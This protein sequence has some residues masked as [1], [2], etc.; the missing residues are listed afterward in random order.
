METENA[1]I[2]IKIVYDI[3]KKDI[4][5]YQILL[6]FFFSLFF[7]RFT[8]RIKC[9]RRMSFKSS[10]FMRGSGAQVV[11]ETYLKFILGLCLMISTRYHN[12]Q[13]NLK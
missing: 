6:M 9:V 4:F 3:G 8:F 11:A 1:L 2:N 5:E 12:T 10:R 7:F 13:N